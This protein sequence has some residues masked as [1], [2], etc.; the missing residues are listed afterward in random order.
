[1]KAEKDIIEKIKEAD[2]AKLP[3]WVIR[4]MAFKSHFTT[5]R[6]AEQAERK[7]ARSESSS[8]TSQWGRALGSIDTHPSQGN[9]APYSLPSTASS[10][11]AAIRTSLSS[12]LAAASSFVL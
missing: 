7:V 8:P 11:D 9:V 3:P 6:A 10:R 2:R 12:R 4:L 5:R 1:M